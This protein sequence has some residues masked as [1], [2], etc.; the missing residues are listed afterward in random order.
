MRDQ[1]LFHG[2]KGRL[3]AFRPL[4][5]PSRYYMYRLPYPRHEVP[6]LDSLVLPFRATC[7]TYEPCVLRDAAVKFASYQVSKSLATLSTSRCLSR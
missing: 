2:Y 7:G 4:L 3:P 1:G 5:L 6:S